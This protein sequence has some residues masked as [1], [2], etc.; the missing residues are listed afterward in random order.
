MSPSAPLI[1]AW[2]SGGVYLETSVN[3]IVPKRGTSLRTGKESRP[4]IAAET[5][6]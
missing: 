4:P 1:W 5:F 3:S 2:V 6:I